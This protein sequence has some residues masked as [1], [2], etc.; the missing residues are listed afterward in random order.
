M[1]LP[2]SR[3]PL[4]HRKA[5]SGVWCPPGGRPRAR[6]RGSR[7]SPRGTVSRAEN[8]RPRPRR[9]RP[10]RPRPLGEG[11]AFALCLKSRNTDRPLPDWFTHNFTTSA[12]SAAVPKGLG[13]AK[14]SGNYFWHPEGSCRTRNY[15][16]R[17]ERTAACRDCAS[18]S[19]KQR[20]HPSGPQRVGA[21]FWGPGTRVRGTGFGLWEEGARGAWY[22]RERPVSA[23]LGSPAIAARLGRSREGDSPGGNPLGP[24][25]PQTPGASPAG[26]ASRSLGRRARSGLRETPRE[27]PA[28][29]AQEALGTRGGCGDLGGGAA[30]CH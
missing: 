10:A 12:G 9:R 24:R 28:P 3:K 21:A 18:P 20:P 14:K 30:S 4:S 25:L 23:E 2:V 13:S 16:R 26:G 7:V 17:L 27:P 19:S 29:G 15:R 6:G 5:A 8:P 1:K 22:R 11:S